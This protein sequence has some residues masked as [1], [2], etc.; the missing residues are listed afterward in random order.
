MKD[1]V[2]V[3]FPPI[4][5]KAPRKAILKRNLKKRRVSELCR[6]ASLKLPKGSRFL[7]PFAER[8]KEKK[9]GKVGKGGCNII[10]EISNR[11]H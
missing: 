2:F 1:P 10:Q 3:C 8:K 9:N 4:F 7:T 6:V 5:S 11:T